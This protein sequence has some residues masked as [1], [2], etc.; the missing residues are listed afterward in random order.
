M[1]FTLKLYTSLNL[2]N[3][4]LQQFTAYSGVCREDLTDLEKKTKTSK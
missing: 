4:F 3:G 1:I 2:D